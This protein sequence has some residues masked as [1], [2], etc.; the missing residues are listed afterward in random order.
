MSRTI[1][2]AISPVHKYLTIFFYHLLHT[3]S[4]IFISH[5]H[6]NF[7]NIVNR[8]DF[9]RVGKVLSY[10]RSGV[11]HWVDRRRPN[12]NLNLDTKSVTSDR[13][14]GNALW[15]SAK[16]LVLRWSDLRRDKS[17][18]LHL[19][20]TQFSYPTTGCPRNIIA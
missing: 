11:D 18:G 7:V 10:A 15:V 4:L 1:K 14:R 6:K 5:F 13:E 12:M 17:P 9:R 8:A 20:T 2:D 3:V 19:W 16:S